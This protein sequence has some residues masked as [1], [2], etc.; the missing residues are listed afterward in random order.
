MSNVLQSF[1]SV[2]VVNIGSSFLVKYSNQQNGGYFSITQVLI[3]LCV[4]GECVHG[5][6]VI[7]L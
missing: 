1:P 7:I 6:V 3:F 5:E 2:T 4:S